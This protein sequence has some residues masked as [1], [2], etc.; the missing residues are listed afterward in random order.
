MSRLG[1]DFVRTRPHFGPML[2]ASQ[3]RACLLLGRGLQKSA[4]RRA[5]VES[6]SAMLTRATA[7]Q[8]KGDEASLGRGVGDG[9]VGRSR[10]AE[11]A[12]ASTSLVP[13]EGDPGR[14]GTGTR[15]RTS[16]RRSLAALARAPLTTT[17]RSTGCGLTSRAPRSDKA[18][19]TTPRRLRGGARGPRAPQWLVQRQDVSHR[20]APLLRWPRAPRRRRGAPATRRPRLG[21]RLWR[22]RHARPA[23]SSHAR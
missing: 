17:P 9:R 14:G 19:T 23:Q 13:R 22:G 18:S 5:A 10:R 11:H 21:R 6:V 4:R 12:R 16:A 7:M 3:Q 1:L 2:L 15:R 20:P 8:L